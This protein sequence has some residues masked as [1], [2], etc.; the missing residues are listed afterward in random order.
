MCLGFLLAL[1]LP[2]I[3]AVWFWSVAIGTR[4]ILLWMTPGTDIYRYIWEGEVQNHGF[5]PYCLAPSSES[6][7]PL[8]NHI[9]QLVKFKEVSAIYP[10][11]AELLLRLATFISA[12]VMSL[13][14]LFVVADLVTCRLLA[15][16]FG[17]ANALIFA[18]N[19]LVIYSFAGGGHYDSVFV[20]SLT[21][22][23]LLWERKG[24]SP[25]GRLASIACMGAGVAL[26][27]LCLPLVGW[28]LWQIA[29]RDGPKWALRASLVAVLPLAASWAVVAAGSWSCSLLPADFVRVARSAEALPAFA[30]W[31]LPPEHSFNRNDFYLGVFL[32]V[33]A[34]LLWRQGSVRRAGQTVL[35]AALLTTPMFHAWYAAWLVP[36]AVGDR[37]RGAI[38]L[39]ISSFVYFWL[40]HTAGQPGGIWKQSAAEKLLLWGPFVIGLAWQK[41]GSRPMK[42]SA[43][44]DRPATG[45]DK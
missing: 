20:L 24:S 15:Q 12:T 39:S 33:S 30:A 2:G 26:K 11:L 43:G 17:C 45:E 37:N 34:F 10:P 9:W 31:I 4:F 19:P 22:A 40:H 14:L 36:L 32:L 6:L 42:E 1:R 27:W 3:P 8:R 44:H 23:W 21:A 25:A 5:S 7:A 13:K 28:E 29:R 18:W 35:A 16:R 38:A 41:W